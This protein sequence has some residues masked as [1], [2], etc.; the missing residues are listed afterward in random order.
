MLTETLLRIPFSVI[1][2]FFLHPKERSRIRDP[3]VRDADPECH[4]SPT[5]APSMGFFFDYSLYGQQ[6]YKKQYAEKA[7]NTDIF[8]AHSYIQQI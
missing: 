2:Q 4:G 6:K 3:L 1:G 8:T 5:L 7:S